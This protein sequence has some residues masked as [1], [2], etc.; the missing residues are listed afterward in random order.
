MFLEIRLRKLVDEREKM[1]EQVGRWFTHCLRQWRGAD[2]WVCHWSPDVLWLHLQVKK[3]KAQLEQKT[4]RN[5]T[6]NSSSPDGE[7]LENGNDPNIIEL[8]SKYT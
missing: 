4:Q 7:I 2:S 8:Q 3:L 6:E 5:G 1:I